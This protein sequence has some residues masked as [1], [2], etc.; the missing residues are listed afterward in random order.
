MKN[1]LVL[2]FILFFQLFFAQ[3][4]EKINYQAVMRDTNGAIIANQN[5]SLEI[6]IIEN[7]ISGTSV[8]TETH[9]LTTTATGLITLQIGTGTTT[10][11]FST[12]QWSETNHFLQ[13]SIDPSGGS[14]YTM[15]STQELVTVPYAF[16]ANTSVSS[17]SLQD[18]DANTKIQVEETTND[19]IIRFD[20]AGHES[21]RLKHSTSNYPI[22]EFIQNPSSIFLGR[23]AGEN[24]SVTNGNN[25]FIGDQTGTNNTTGINNVLLGSAALSM[26]QSSS[27]VTAVGQGSG[28]N[29]TGDGH[30]FLGYQAG[31]DASGNNK[32]YIEN[33]AS[34]TPLI[35]GE[36]DNDLVR[37]NGTLETTSNTTIEGDLTVN[38]S[39]T[40]SAGYSTATIIK[41]SIFRN[42]I[43]IPANFPFR[44]QDFTILGAELGDVVYVT[45]SGQLDR[46]IVIGQAWVISNDTVRVRFVGAQNTDP[47]GLG[48][49]YHFVIIK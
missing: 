34:Q 15:I 48:L 46:D 7:S 14:N 41:A 49:T 33:S 26:S 40:N 22:L 5:I 44:L 1:I 21:V 4:P 16:H 9:N 18:T 10:S 38:G 12:I 20:I 30:V 13:V 17:K 2:F 35:Y 36:F 24:T 42:V 3:T 25:I 28:V 23:N 29:A 27:N 11:S 19:N 6:S 47:D 8:Y 32:L 37:I 39:I 43:P 45:P 31:S